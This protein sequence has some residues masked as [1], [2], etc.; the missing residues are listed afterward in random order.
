M[1]RIGLNET[2]RVLGPWDELLRFDILSIIDDINGI[3]IL[4]TDHGCQR[5]MILFLE[6]G[7]SVRVTDE[8]NLFGYL[9]RQINYGIYTVQNSEFLNWAKEARGSIELVKNMTNLK[10]FLI[11]S[12]NTVFEYI[13][14]EPPQ[15]LQSPNLQS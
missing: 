5:K 15:V 7:E 9:D 4:I 1:I 2:E 12:S 10:H 3:Q 8:G 6:T 14:S 11:Y 13:G